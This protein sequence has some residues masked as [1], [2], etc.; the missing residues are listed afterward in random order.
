MS[1]NCLR[2]ERSACIDEA[3]VKLYYPGTLPSLAAM[4]AFLKA[5]SWLK[6]FSSWFKL[7]IQRTFIEGKSFGLADRRCL[8][9]THVSQ[10]CFLSSFLC[11]TVRSHAKVTRPI[12]SVAHFVCFSRRSDGIAHLNGTD[13]L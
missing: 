8:Y 9:A 11:L 7:S 3:F 13:R 10:F 12:A 4:R 1:V 5:S 6:P 2:P